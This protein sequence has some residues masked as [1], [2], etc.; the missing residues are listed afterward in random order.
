MIPLVALAG[1][2]ESFNAQSNT[3]SERF[4]S[5]EG[6]EAAG[7]PKYSEEYQKDF[8]FLFLSFAVSLIAYV[9]LRRRRSGRDYRTMPYLY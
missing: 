2:R 6:S 7:T 3:L 5:L 1:I 9:F 8:E 4:K